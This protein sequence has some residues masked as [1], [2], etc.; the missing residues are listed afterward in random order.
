LPLRTLPV[1]RGGGAGGAAAGFSAV[2][3]LTAR[4]LPLALIVAGL[5][6]SVLGLLGSLPERV[7]VLLSGCSTCMSSNSCDAWGL[8]MNQTER[9]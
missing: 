4:A 3:D 7:P 8:C 6:P 2:A 5:P 1:A 9:R